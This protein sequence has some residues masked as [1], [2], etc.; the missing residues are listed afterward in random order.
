MHHI[1]AMKDLKPNKSWVDKLM[2]KAKRKQI[3]LCRVCH[4]KKHN[5]LV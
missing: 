4:M 2:M 1:R 3:P 5:H